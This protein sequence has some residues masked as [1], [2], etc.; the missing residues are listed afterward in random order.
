MIDFTSVLMERTLSMMQ[1]ISV[2]AA[3][4]ASKR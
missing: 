4:I 2:P 3:T 1:M